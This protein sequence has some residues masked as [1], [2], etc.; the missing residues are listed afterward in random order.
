MSN[1][2]FLRRH[3]FRY[4]KENAFIEKYIEHVKRCLVSG[5]DSALLAAKG[6]A[7]VR[8]YGDV[9]KETMKNWEEFSNLTN[10]KIM[11]SFLDNFF[12]E[13]RFEN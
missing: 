11:S 8:G 9:R 3:S 5:S 7:I 12:Y 1:L 6:G 10:P 2:R 4:G 13:K